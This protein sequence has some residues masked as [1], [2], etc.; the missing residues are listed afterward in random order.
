MLVEVTGG[1]DSGKTKFV[2]QKVSEYLQNNVSSI[3]Y[4]VDADEQLSLRALRQN[5]IDEN[6]FYYSNKLQVSLFAAADFVVI[7]SLFTVTGNKSVKKFL[8]QLRNLSR[9][10]NVIL[11]NQKRYNTITG[12]IT[13]FYSDL[14]T[15]FCDYSL[16]LDTKKVTKNAVAS[17]EKMQ[18]VDL[19]LKSFSPL[20]LKEIK[21][22][23]TGVL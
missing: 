11:V 3:I 6:R 2:L 1:P 13:R 5:K 10:R 12:V 20:E 22:L 18:A 23:T 15:R 21:D 7:D 16:D 8:F 14:V 19:K 4:Y 9:N 17:I